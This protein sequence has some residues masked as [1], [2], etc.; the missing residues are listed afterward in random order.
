MNQT[1]LLAD[2]S[3]TIQRI[4]ELTFAAENIAVVP[5]SD[6]EHAIASLDRSLPDIVLADIG[7]PGRS[8]YE[9]SRYIKNSPPLA[10][11]P[12]LLLTGAFEPVDQAKAL[13]AGCD[14]IL[15][16]PFEPQFVINRVKEL[17]R[18]PKPGTKEA[19]V[20]EYFEELDKAFANLSASQPPGVLLEPH[21]ESTLAAA[22][23]LSIAHDEPSSHSLE[24]ELSA[25][26]PVSAASGSAGSITPD[27]AR[28]TPI[29]EPAKVAPAPAAV[30][31]A[32]ATPA[33]TAPRPSLAEAFAALLAA[34]RSGNGHSTLSAFAPTPRPIPVDDIVEQV[35]RRVIEQMTDSV[36][37]ETVTNIVSATAERMVR[38]EIER[39]KSNIK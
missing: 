11:I 17:L 4:V 30:A 39:I 36:V 20:E 27:L 33:A 15:I 5:F 29:A 28:V 24:P 19:E 16:K 9:I 32:T 14:G 2:A 18:K 37:R 35:T 3:S 7:M 34:E 6:G 12:V 31:A 10:H 23:D 26:M 38:E 1:L 13:E 25:E 22:G 21:V 8:G